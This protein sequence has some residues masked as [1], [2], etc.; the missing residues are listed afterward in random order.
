MR[1]ERHRGRLPDGA[2]AALAGWLIHLR[3][4]DVRDP[5]AAELRTLAQSPDAT[6][7]VLSTLDH[8][9]AENQE[10]IASVDASIAY[11]TRR[12]GEP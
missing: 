1:A 8:D 11:L 12:R 2:T 3:T 9:L 6:R 7:R 4:E 10:L 5:R